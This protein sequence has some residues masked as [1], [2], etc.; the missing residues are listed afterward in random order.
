RTLNSIGL[1]YSSLGQHQKALEYFQQALPIERAVSDR[2]GEAMALNNI[3]AVYW[4]LGERQKALEYYQQAL[5]VER[6]LGDREGEAVILSWLM[7]WWKE[8]HN[9]PLAIFFGKQ[10]VNVY[11][12]LRRDIQGLDKDIQKTYVGTITGAYRSLADLLLAEGRLPEAEQVLGMLK[13]QEFKEF[14][15]GRC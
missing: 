8:Q 2:G 1:V 11:Q 12:S 3:G 4:W 5:P 9:R 15:R 6:A 10:A 13:E 14:T 7:T